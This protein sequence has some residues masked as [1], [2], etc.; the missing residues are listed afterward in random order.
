[1]IIVNIDGRTGARIGVCQAATKEG[2][3]IDAHLH[4]PAGTR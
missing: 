2:D 1:M 4:R 3:A